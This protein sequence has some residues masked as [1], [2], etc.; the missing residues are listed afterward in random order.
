MSTNFNQNEQTVVQ[1]ETYEK[2]RPLNVTDDRQRPKVSDVSSSSEKF[3]LEL[4]I[5]FD[6]ASNETLKTD[7]ENGMTKSYFKSKLFE[8]VVS[9][10]NSIEKISPDQH[11]R[12]GIDLGNGS[13]TKSISNHQTDSTK[14]IETSRL[15]FTDPF[16]MQQYPNY[17]YQEENNALNSDELHSKFRWSIKTV[18]V[19]C[20][21]TFL[22]LI[23]VFILV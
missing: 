9:P 6:R 23:L 17:P 22:V 10:S 11:C 4:P 14:F 19:A 21:S 18:T 7:D 3:S 8:C 5:D 16:W 13:I 20:L 1:T 15:P 2:L 12:Y